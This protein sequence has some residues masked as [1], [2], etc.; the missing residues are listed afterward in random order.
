MRDSPLRRSNRPG[1]VLMRQGSGLESLDTCN[2]CLAFLV[3]EIAV[4]LMHRTGEIITGA[5]KLL[6]G[7]SHVFSLLRAWMTPPRGSLQNRG[8]IHLQRSS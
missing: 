4:V 1:I 7:G 6:D 3:G 5:H 2:N 8:L